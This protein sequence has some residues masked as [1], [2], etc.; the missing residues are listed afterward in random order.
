MPWSKF[1]P[2]A[3]M[4]FLDCISNT[5]IGNRV[6]LSDGEEGE[7]VYINRNHYSRPT[8]KISS[9]KFID[10]SERKDL[11]IIGII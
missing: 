7:V 8:I 6:R 2:K 11:E 4:I 5:Y 1:D 3:L 9:N 10:L